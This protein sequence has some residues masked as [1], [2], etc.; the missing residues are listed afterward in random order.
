[1][2]AFLQHWRTFLLAPVSSQGFRLMRRVWACAVFIKMITQ[3]SQLFV[4]FAGPQN[5]RQVIYMHPNRTSLLLLSDTPSFVAII[6]ILMLI[7]CALLMV[8]RWQKYAMP[9][10]W[11]AFI[12][13]FERNAGPF[14]S[15][16]S[17][18]SS[19][20]FI[21]LL[22]TYLEN[23]DQRTMPAFLWRLLLWQIVVMYVTSVWYKFLSATWV[24]GGGVAFAFTYTYF[25]TVFPKI[26]AAIPTPLRILT[27]IVMAWEAAWILLLV[28]KV[29][30]S[31]IRCPSMHVI[32][33]RTLMLIGLVM[34]LAWAILL[35]EV[36]PL[37]L[38]AFAMYAGLL[39]PE[40][41]RAISRFVRRQ[42]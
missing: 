5:L 18:L 41:F 27:F 9:I 13:F 24:H 3:A 26:A 32:V 12:S 4:L 40:D 39:Q 33:R 21:L 34:H 37:S 17:M 20:G 29:T 15:E 38:A 22:F 1:M 31:W 10:A 25:P 30:W 16:T 6:Y 23:R 2:T 35:R 19:S 36:Y 28:P 42:K 7:A 8:E 14:R 11:I